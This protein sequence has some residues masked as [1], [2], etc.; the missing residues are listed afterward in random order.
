LDLYRRTPG[1][2]SGTTLTGAL[3][4]AE[5]ATLPL[6]DLMSLDFDAALDDEHSSAW[7]ELSAL[8]RV[9]VYQAAGMVIAQLGVTAAEALVRIRGYAYAHDTTASRVAYD[10][11]ERRLRLADDQTGTGPKEPRS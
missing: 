1:R 3:L 6:L 2:F 11:I 4:A 8:T 9:E 10:I 5:L 7:Q